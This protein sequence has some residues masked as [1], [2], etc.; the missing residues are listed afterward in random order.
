MAGLK[1]VDCKK[2]DFHIH[3]I[4][5]KATFFDFRGSW[6]AKKI[7]SGRAMG[8]SDPVTVAPNLT[9]TYV[10]RY[11]F[12]ANDSAGIGISFGC[13]V[14]HSGATWDNEP[15]FTF[16]YRRW[17]TKLFCLFENVLYTYF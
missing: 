8:P 7:K 14:K 5:S 4:V 3:D 9:D 1:I 6:L 13:V 11:F 2:N 12:D 17:Q 15:S 10:L 16:C